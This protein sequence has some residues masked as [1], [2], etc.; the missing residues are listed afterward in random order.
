MIRLLVIFSCGAVVGG[1]LVWKFAPARPSQAAL[2]PIVSERV[3]NGCIGELE[4]ARTEIVELR[5]EARAT[6][7]QLA[8]ETSPN[9]SVPEPQ[10]TA[11]S[12]Q[13]SR[14]GD[15]VRWKVSAIEKF[16]PLSDDQRQ[17][18]TEKFEK[19][20]VAPVG[21]ETDTQSL[22]DIVGEENARFYRQQV[23]AA[24]QRVQDEEIDREVVWLSRQ[25]ALS[26]DQERSMR[27]VFEVVEREI[28]QDGEEGGKQEARTPQ[29]RVKAM[30]E[31][32]RKRT[33]LRNEQLKPVLSPE[34][35]EAYLRTQAESPAADVELF[36]N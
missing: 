2:S 15:A 27:S 26:Q 19:E 21:A 28:D 17:R 1:A 22:E 34:Q 6:R 12:E 36:H 16:V 24:F 10:E 18:L 30:V 29:E 32:N 35:Y 25:L 9:H 14:I 31:E 8:L 4:A 3:D 11:G 7:D 5:R 13:P 23:K 20:A 33:E